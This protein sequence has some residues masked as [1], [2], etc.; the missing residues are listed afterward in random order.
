MV[1]HTDTCTHVEVH[2]CMHAL[3]VVLC[4]HTCTTLLQ[5]YGKYSTGHPETSHG[6]GICTYIVGNIAIFV[7]CDLLAILFLAI[8]TTN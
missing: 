8:D 5:M 6:T 4:Y 1:L 7:S 3:H 2:V